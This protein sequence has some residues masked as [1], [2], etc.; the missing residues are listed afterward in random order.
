MKLVHAI[1]ILY[2]REVVYFIH[3]TFST[4]QQNQ[5]TAIHSRLFSLLEPIGQ[6][7]VEHDSPLYIAHS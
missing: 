4:K 3:R 6:L 7:H 5:Q 1:L 2:F